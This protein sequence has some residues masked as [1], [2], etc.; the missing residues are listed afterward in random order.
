MRSSTT[1][2]VA[3]PL[4][5]SQL[6][7][8]TLQAM[9]QDRQREMH[10]LLQHRLLQ[11]PVDGTDNGLDESEHAEAD[12][13]EHIAVALIQLKGDTLRRIREALVR[14]EAGDYG[15]CADCGCEISEKRLQALPFAL[16][17]T[18]CESAHEQGMASD[19]KFGLRQSAPLLFAP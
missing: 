13:Q 12:I 7:H 15:D 5:G 3:N 14:L 19:R 4:N 16:R 1:T 8:R 2:A 17:C 11:A 6:R 10:A 18:G 9:L